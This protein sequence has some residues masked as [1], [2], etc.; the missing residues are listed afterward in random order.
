M[1]KRLLSLLLC[2]LMAITMLPSTV[3]AADSAVVQSNIQREET[4]WE[5]GYLNDTEYEFYEILKSQIQQKAKAGGEMIFTLNLQNMS[6]DNG[7]ETDQEKIREMA[8]D[9]LETQIRAERIL[10]C[11]IQD[12]PYE[13][14]WYDKMTAF[15]YGAGISTLGNT[16]TITSMSF[17]LPVY[18]TYQ[19]VGASEPGYTLS[20]AAA[21]DAASD[22]ANALQIV[23]ANKGKSDLEKLQAYKEAIC[24]LVSYDWE[25]GEIVGDITNPLYDTFY[26]EPFQL[27]SVFDNNP[28]TKAVCEGYAKAFQYLCDMSE[29]DD[30][31]CYSVSGQ[32]V[33][34]SGS[35]DI[36]GVG[37]M[38]N[39]VRIDGTSYLVDITNC[40]ESTSGYPDLFFMKA[41]AGG[42]VQSGYVM[43]G[44]NGS[45]FRFEYA[46][47]YTADGFFSTSV[48][49]L[50]GKYL[51]GKVS[52]SGT[53]KIGEVLTAET[54]DVPG[55]AVLRYQ[56]YRGDQA[57]AGANGK[58][59]TPESGDD[60]GKT[61]KVEITADGYQGTLSAQTAGTVIKA[62][63]EKV[64]E[65]QFVSVT[66]TSITVATHEGEEYACVEYDNIK[67][68]DEDQWQESGEFSGLTA[69]KV[70]VIFARMKET[71]THNA[72]P[73]AEY[74]YAYT[75]TSE[76]LIMNVE[77]EIPSPVKYQ[78]L[79]DK[80]TL[81]TANMTA[82]V[83]WYEGQTVSDDQQPVTG[84]AKPN[85]YYTAKVTLIADEGYSFANGCN[86]NING[87]TLQLPAQVS[88]FAM[89]Y[90]FSAPT[91]PVEL[92][93]IQVTRQPD[94]TTY[95][96]GDRFDPTG[97]EI[98]GYYDDG[99][100]GPISIADCTFDPE[101]IALDTA[102][103][104][105]AYNGKTAT[106]PVTVIPP[107]QLEYI[108][109]TRKPDKTEYYIGEK[110]DPTGMEI[111]GYYDD[112][113]YEIIPIESC[114]FTPE[115]MTADTNTVK[116]SYG[117]MEATVSVI[118]RERPIVNADISVSAPRKYVA[119]DTDISWN[120]TPEGIASTMLKWYEGTDTAGTPVTGKAE[121]SQVYTVQI[122]FSA[123]E[124][125]IFPE[126]YCVQLNGELLFAQILD[127]GKTAVITKTFPATEEALP[128]EMIPVDE[129]Y[130]PDD[131]FRSYVNTFDRDKDGYLS[132]EERNQ[133]TY[134]NVRGK[135]IKSL[136]GVEYFS[137]LN[138]L[139][140]SNNQLTELDFSSN[141]ELVKL[142]CSNNQ[143]VS[144]N[145]SNNTK[146]EVCQCSSNQLTTLDVTNNPE[147][148]DLVCANNQLKELDVSNNSKLI[149]LTCYSNQLTGLDFSNN[150]EL[151]ELSCGYN[152]LP[153]LDLSNNPKVEKIA[154][155]GNQIAR[156]DVTA[157][158]NLD[159]LYVHSN[160]LTELDLSNN[161]KLWLLSCDMNQ[162]SILD[163]SNN[164]ELSAMSC[165]SN[166]LLELDLSNNSKLTDISVEG[167]TQDREVIRSEDGSWNFDLS[168]VVRSYEKVGNIQVQNAT[169]MDDGKTIHW[170]G[171]TQRPVVT[172]TYNM[173]I[174]SM[175]VVLN[176]IPLGLRNDTGVASVSVDGVYGKVSG[177][178][179]SVELPYG[180]SLPESDTQIVITA[181]DTE[182]EVSGLASA[183]QGA[184][185]TF[186]VTAEDGQTAAKYTVHV[187]VA[188]PCIVSFDANEGTGMMA[189]LELPEGNY[190]L[191][192][193][194]FTPPEG[195][196]F[197]AWS[198]DGT[199]YD[200]N[201]VIYLKDSITVSAVWE[202][203]PA[204]I[205]GA[206]GVWQKGSEKDLSFTA[207]TA[208]ADFLKVQVDGQDLDE[209]DYEVREGSTIV[210][211]KA[212]YLETLSVGKH[213]LSIVSKN[214]S[215]ITTFTI[216]KEVQNQTQDEVKDETENT[217]DNTADNTPEN[218]DLLSP[219]TQEVDGPAL[220][221]A[222][223]LLS[224]A[225]G[226]GVIV[227]G[228]KRRTHKK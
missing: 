33:T 216:Q 34:L 52:I 152:Q 112:S 67:I 17:Y 156:I 60:V 49:D 118:V 206:E 179:I 203:I 108:Q 163:L 120:N 18:E 165:S 199:E 184:T 212:S 158:E 188:D 100:N 134:I 95:D 21:A 204:I 121:A 114:T 122:V 43:L 103:V 157:C 7:G 12:L 128:L 205:E 185:W 178:D 30:V 133:V 58:T 136:E 202:L 219:A 106:V 90:S 73:T 215:A 78:D 222:L 127:N 164:P 8:W 75:T 93:S 214:G 57:I 218:N 162:L 125:N 39:I 109:V 193:C 10:I 1:K 221:L 20:A 97:M 225:A 180:S 201:K 36:P 59:Y 40:D 68:P 82:T 96:V 154:C 19:D 50:S 22:V 151:L 171:K 113:S 194:A 70:Y 228:Q 130:F 150:P 74:E 25:A 24:N 45:S 64:Q 166:Q 11:L 195:Y 65:V 46:A 16:T 13:M 140:C 155:Y 92:T 94:K 153:E 101:I 23:N 135:E 139:D 28:D 66:K 116:I 223:L 132:I 88:Q 226:L 227:S 14:F 31:K 37:H 148:Q 198:I 142:T 86:L 9:Y 182:A 160:L 129:D 208:F 124:E 62:D 173:G 190:A 3:W 102:N 87:Q 209:T 131:N 44:N 115:T 167:Q 183:D 41:P 200:E 105:V 159:I 207:N 98:T 211:L 110:F 172:Y 169:L 63:P 144:L 56:W 146:L 126:N 145:V 147:M 29:F 53:T 189:S 69:G 76:D 117:E 141:T 197:K 83:E 61:I 217:A 168:A 5:A 220:W 47:Q 77:V 51:Y 99:S 138:E 89:K 187:S 186:T 174:G 170:D 196:R 104:T 48:L 84:K 15:Q 177:T 81:K 71:P 119:L 85:Q 35:S 27:T 123:S 38:W 213:T 91:A 4:S 176:L 2:F 143:L 79:P 42:N 55:G 210:T 175:N 137:Y 149:Y 32:M 181:S 72:T 111:T 107:K 192:E 224:G 6:F 80:V 54:E 161:P 191:P 26:G